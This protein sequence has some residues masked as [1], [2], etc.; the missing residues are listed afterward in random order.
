MIHHDRCG[1]TLG[2]TI[3]LGIVVAVLSIP[4]GIAVLLYR[5]RRPG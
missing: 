2:Q 3:I 5:P 1:M 4:V